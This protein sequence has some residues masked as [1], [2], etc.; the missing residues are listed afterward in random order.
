MIKINAFVLP[1]NYVY[2]VY[3]CFKSKAENMHETRI[4]I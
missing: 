3:S 4:L 1:N 2:P